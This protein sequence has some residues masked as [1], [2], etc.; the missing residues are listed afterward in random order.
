[1]NAKVGLHYQAEDGHYFTWSGAVSMSVS[2]MSG[3]HEQAAQI[4][5]FQYTDFRPDWVLAG[6]LSV[7]LAF[8]EACDKWIKAQKES[9]SPCPKS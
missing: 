1:M 8:Q 3:A 7:V 9:G 5:K 2:V 6:T 4:D